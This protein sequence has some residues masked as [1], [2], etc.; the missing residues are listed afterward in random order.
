MLNKNLI[1]NYIINN[2]NKLKI[3]SNEIVNG[4]IFLALQGNNCHGN[5]FIRSKYK[6]WGKILFN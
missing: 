5:K 6:Q 1:E 4:D 3:N 2:E